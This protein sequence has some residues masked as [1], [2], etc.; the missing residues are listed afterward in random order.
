MSLFFKDDPEPPQPVQIDPRKTAAA[1]FEYGQKAALYNKQLAEST[2]QETPYGTVRYEEVTPSSSSRIGGKGSSSLDITPAVTKRIQELH[3]AEQALL[4]QQRALKG[5]YGDVA[6]QLMGKASNLFGTPVDTSSLGPMPGSDR[7][8]NAT[9]SLES[10][11]GRV[12]SEE[13]KREIADRLRGYSESAE[14]IRL[15]AMP[16]SAGAAPIASSLGPMPSSDRATFDTSSLGVMPG[17]AWGFDT[18]SLGAMPVA[19]EATRQSIVNSL[20]KRY[21]PQQAQDRSAL[22]TQLANQGFVRGSAAWNSAMDEINRKE[23]DFRIAADLQ[24]GGEMRADLA[25]QMGI[26]GQSLQELLASSGEMRADL[27]Q[28]MGIR[29]QS[30]QELLAS[31]GERRA[32]LAQQM[33]IRGQSLQELLA[34]SG[35]RRADVAQQMGIRGQSFAEQMGIRG[36]NLQEMLARGNVERAN[37]AQQLGIR[38]QSMQELLAPRNQ[39]LQELSTFMT[40]S[41]PTM[42]QFAPV[43]SA[44]VAAPDYAGLVAANAQMQNQANMAAYNAASGGGGIGSGL[45]S[46]VGGVAGA[47][48]GGPAGAMAGSSIGGQLGS[49]I[50]S[51][52]GGQS[53]YSGQMPGG[54]TSSG[55][56]SF[57]AS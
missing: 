47:Y 26:R 1:Q 42:P 28:Q 19:N 55:G 34:S 27:A 6:G 20:M 29:G 14:A 31:S 43:S 16:V 53:T 22:E 54:A 48:F 51:S 41:Q 39:T 37:I 57:G 9:T 3:P 13:K 32:D 49:S 21:Q 11:A 7:F 36:Q 46:L 52:G 18:S 12:F 38:G 17:G 40:G 56:W 8:L 15:G 10:D 33:G 30:L 2:W 50:G 24:S 45:G 23:T 4:D 25:Q 5:Q 35:E 44:Q